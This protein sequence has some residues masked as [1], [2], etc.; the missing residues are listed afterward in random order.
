M[1][2]LAANFNGLKPYLYFILTFVVVLGWMDGMH[3]LN[4]LSCSENN[5]SMILRLSS[6][7]QNVRTSNFLRGLYPPGSL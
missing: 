7:L 1:N 6:K 3:A 5:F 2:I 4:S